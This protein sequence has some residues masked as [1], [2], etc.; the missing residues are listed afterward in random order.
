[1]TYSSVVSRDSVRIALTITA[2]NGLKV[3]GCDIQNT[4][5]YLTAKCREI[6]WTIAGPEFGT[7]AGKIMIVVRV[8]YD[9]KSNSV[10]FRVLLAE[11]LY[12]A[13]YRSLCVD[14]DVWMRPGM[15]SNGFQYWELVLCYVDH[16]FIC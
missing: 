13:G 11:I 3:L 8:L 6:I 5:F 14:P 15:K 9:L 10:A 1:M 4:Y 2:L 16:V 12:D 7:D